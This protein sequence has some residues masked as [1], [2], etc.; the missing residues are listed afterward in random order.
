MTKAHFEAI[1][2]SFK[3]QRAE[4][5]N[6]D[7]FADDSAFQTLRSTAIRQAAL[8]AEFNPRFDSRRFL[9]ACGF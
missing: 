4:L 8:F 9:T 3:S 2:A 1:A 6:T 7:G 5:F